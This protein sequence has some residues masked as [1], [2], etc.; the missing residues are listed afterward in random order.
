M[1][2]ERAK[3]ERTNN[4]KITSGVTEGPGDRRGVALPLYPRR[5]GY[6]GCTALPATA[7][8]PHISVLPASAGGGC[9]HTA[10]PAT[11][12]SFPPVRGFPA[13]P[14]QSLLFMFRIPRSSCRASRT[15]SRRQSRSNHR[16]GGSPGTRSTSAIGVQATI[17]SVSSWTIVTRM[18]Q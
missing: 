15:A 3:P 8:R 18:A 5:P 10:E 13:P 6:D 14:A 12:E 17:V 16:R 1:N 11:S 2:G 9:R 4:G 7:P